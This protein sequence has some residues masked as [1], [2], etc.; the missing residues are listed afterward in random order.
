[1]ASCYSSSCD[2]GGGIAP[3]P[4]PVLGPAY[5][6]TGPSGVPP[7]QPFSRSTVAALA[8]LPRNLGL[9][10]TCSSLSLQRR[11]RLHRNRPRLS[12]QWQRSHRLLLGQCRPHRRA[13]LMHIER[14]HPDTLAVTGPRTRIRKR[15]DRSS[16]GIS[17]I[18]RT[19]YRHKG[20]SKGTIVP[21]G[22]ACPRTTLW[23]T[24][25]EA[26][27]EDR[28]RRRMPAPRSKVGTG[29]AT[30]LRGS[31][32]FRAGEGEP[33]WYFGPR[34]GIPSWEGSSAVSLSV[35]GLGVCTTIQDVDQGRNY[36]F[37]ALWLPCK[38]VIWMDDELVSSMTGCNVLL[39]QHKRRRFQRI[40]SEQDLAM[41]P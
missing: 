1:M 19:G 11:L 6:A 13:G 3:V 14:S 17:L 29:V 2:G 35:A 22:A 21:S 23:S 8:K 33:R 28:S 12:W 38:L 10:Y 25:R 32:M 27:S 16:A 41:S 39:Y 7:H 20:A 5:L 36:L 34:R 24:S 40:Q 18:P 26:S 37:T 15:V 9:A 4:A 30:Y 31:T